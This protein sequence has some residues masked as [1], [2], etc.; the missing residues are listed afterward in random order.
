MCF[1]YLISIDWKLCIIVPDNFLH[2]SL[3]SEF[4]KI[5][6]VNARE[7]EVFVLCYQIPFKVSKRSGSVQVLFQLFLI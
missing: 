2:S 4:Q 7:E 5:Y 3:V 1:H 6:F